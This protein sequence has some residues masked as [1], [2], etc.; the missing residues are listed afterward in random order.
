MQRR[1][2]ESFP[3]QFL[4]RLDMFLSLFFLADRRGNHLEERLF[5]F[6]AI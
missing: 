1:F 2:E 6:Q 3:G 5:Q 4:R